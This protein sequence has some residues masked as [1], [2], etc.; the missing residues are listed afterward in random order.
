M[1]FAGPLKE[2]VTCTIPGQNRQGADSAKLSTVSG[3]DAVLN[4]SG[5][6]LRHHAPVGIFDRWGA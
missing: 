3:I 4:Q 1:R 2:A 5:E 6:A